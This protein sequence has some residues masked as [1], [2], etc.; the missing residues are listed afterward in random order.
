MKKDLGNKNTVKIIFINIANFDSLQRLLGFEV[1]N[2]FLSE[3]AI[4]L[5][6]LIFFIKTF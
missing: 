3:I 6:R 2:N 1:M 5:E 4:G